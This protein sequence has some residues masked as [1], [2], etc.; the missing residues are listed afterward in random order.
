M[1]LK[2]EK[3]GPPFDTPVT[4]VIGRLDRE[5]GLAQR[6]RYAETSAAKLIEA[7]E[8]LAP[9]PAAKPADVPSTA[10]SVALSYADFVVALKAALRQ[11]SRPDLLAS[12]PLMLSRLLGSKGH[13][14][15]SDLQ[16]LLAQTVETLFTSPRD[17]KLRRVIEVTYF[18][19]APKQEAGAERLSLPF[20]TYRRHLTTA[21]ARL[22][23][24][25]WQRERA[26]LTGEVDPREAAIGEDAA[27]SAASH[28]SPRLSIV[29]L[30]F[31]NLGSCNGRD[32]FVDGVT[33]SLTTD[34][35]RIPGALVIAR[36]TAYAY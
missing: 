22:A 24:W 5:I 3:R 12:N 13:A 2:Q 14:G 32:N 4:G 15:P 27:S 25:L 6:L 33:D 28:E 21:L 19:P 30:P 16:A 36:N 18:R 8:L 20:S 23:H 9:G 10:P 17:E 1:Q 35:S 34:L 11:F 26:A 31:L 29:V 7:S